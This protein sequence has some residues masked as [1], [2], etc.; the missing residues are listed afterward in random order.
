MRLITRI[1]LSVAI[2]IELIHMTELLVK[3]LKVKIIVM[4]RFKGKYSKHNNERNGKY[5]RDFHITSRISKKIQISEK[6]IH[7]CYIR[8]EEKS[9][10]LKTS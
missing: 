10:N 4:F 7:E 9:V 5:K 6:S 8:I 1:K 3:D 2:D